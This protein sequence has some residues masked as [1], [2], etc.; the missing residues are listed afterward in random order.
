MGV[1][2]YSNVHVLPCR[3]NCILNVT[4]GEMRFFCDGYEDNEISL[5][6]S[7]P[8]KVFP[9]F[10]T[11]P[12]QS[13]VAELILK[14]VDGC[15]SLKKVIFGNKVDSRLHDDVLPSMEVL[16]CAKSSWRQINTQSSLSEPV[17]ATVNG[18]AIPPLIQQQLLFL[19]LPMEERVLRFSEIFEDSQFAE[20][21]LEICNTLKAC[22][23]CDNVEAG[24]E[25]STVHAIT[26]I[27]T[28][29]CMCM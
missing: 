22:C 24:K 10:I 14:P 20:F 1:V 15:L 19:M 25:V 18:C 2:L 28:C 17:P 6:A 3:A 26:C 13:L 16:H 12:T 9:M 27:Y 7:I 11:T 29:T 5:K 21:H 23:M 8:S 4:K